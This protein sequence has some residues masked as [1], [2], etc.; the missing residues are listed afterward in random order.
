MAV[1]N[2]DMTCPNQPYELAKR[3]QVVLYHERRSCDVDVVCLNPHL[4]N[5]RFIRYIMGLS[6]IGG[7]VYRESH[8]L[9]DFD[10]LPLKFSK[11][12]IG[13]RQYQ[14]VLSHDRSTSPH[15]V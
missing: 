15:I 2:L 13:G 10:I 1:D 3:F 6:H 8:T 9:Q 12:F 4:L 14:N 11:E 5:S 7:V